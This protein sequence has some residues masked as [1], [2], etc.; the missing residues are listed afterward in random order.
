LQE[1]SRAALASV[2]SLDDPAYVVFTSGT[3]GLPRGVVGTHR[4]L[5]H[6]FE[7]HVRQFGFRRSDRFSMLS[8]LSHDPLLR[9]IFT[10]LTVG[11]TVFIPRP[12]PF[13]NPE[14]LLGWLRDEQISV[15]HIVPSL[16]KILVEPKAGQTLPHLRLV[17]FGG[18]ALYLPLVEGLRQLAPEVGVANFYGTTETPQAVGCY[19]LPVEKAGSRTVLPRLPQQNICI[20]KG[21]QNVQLLLLNRAGRLAGIGEVGEICVRTPYLAKGYLDH[22]DLTQERFVRNP[23]TTSPEDRIYKTGDHGRFLPD[24]N[25]LFTGRGDDQV[26]IRGYRVE[27]GEIESVL[28]THPQILQAALAVQEHGP[29]GKV[30]LTAFVVPRAGSCPS[31]ADLRHFLLQR[32]PEYMVPVNFTNLQSLPLTPNGKVDRNALAGL[33]LDAAETVSVLPDTPTEKALARIWCHLLGKKQV[34]IQ[35]NF[36]ESGGYSLLAMSMVSQIKRDL[37]IDLTLRMIFQYPTIQSLA[38][39]IAKPAAERKKSELIHFQAGVSG[40]D[41]IFLVDEGSF[42]FFKLVPL[43][44]KD[45]SLYISVSHLPPAALKASAQNRLNDLPTMPELAARHVALIKSRNSGRPIILA[46]HCFGGNLATEVAAQLMQQGEEVKAILMI[47]TWMTEPGWWWGI[48][49]WVR[50]HLKNLLQNGPNYF[51]HKSQRRVRIEK[52][53]QARQMRLLADENNEFNVPWSAVLRVYRRARAADIWQRPVVPCRG[54][55]FLSRD[56]WQSNAYRKIDNN[57]GANR[58]FVNKVE[59]VD[60]PGDHVTVLDEKHLPELAQCFNDALRKIRGLN[61]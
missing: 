18:E 48:R 8:G 34:G 19:L 61:S 51:W 4:P 7:W 46:G 15:V 33:K 2:P 16:A 43:L 50:A 21:I 28:A 9:D 20:G 52:E 53:E 36:F 39:Q 5:A 26:K 32:L 30:N 37:R 11:A 13:W 27:L 59:V 3:T 29:D 10:P 23:Y 49:A 22:H 42:G 40:P 56:D 25:I 41:L 57:L 17:C 38:S 45:L 31:K 35:D 44:D 24:G 12:T 55:L 6:F 58:W 14:S 60:V 1:Y 54:T 47:D